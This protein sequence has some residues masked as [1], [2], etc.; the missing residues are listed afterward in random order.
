MRHR[1]AVAMLEPAQLD[2]A[3]PTVWADLGSGDG[4]FTRA[5]AE[6]LAT[7]S[8]IHAMDR[9]RWAL[10]RL[11]AAHHGVRIEAHRGDF[12]IEPWPFEPLDGILMANAL[13]YV[14]DQIAFIRRC[15]GHLRPRRRFVIVEYDTD[16]ANRWVPYPVGRAALATCFAAAGYTSIEILG[17]R[18]SIYRA[19]PLYAALVA[20]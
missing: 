5:L 12:T 14:R 9:S 17:S 3:G 2:G 4:T 19:A 6:R 10:A 13:H 1:D 11:P 8:T 7:G 16:A 20:P 15:D 18:P